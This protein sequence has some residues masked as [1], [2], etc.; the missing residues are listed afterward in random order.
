MGLLCP[1]WIHLLN[2]LPP[3]PQNLFVYGVFTETFYLK[4]DHLG[5]VLIQYG[6]CPK[7]R[8]N[9]DI[10]MY[11]QEESCVNMKVDIYKP[12]RE[13]QNRY[14]P[15]NPQK[16]PRTW[17]WTANPLNQC[18]PLIIINLCCLGSLFVILCYGIPSKLIQRA[19]S[20]CDNKL[21]LLLEFNFKF[22][23]DYSLVQT[24]DQPD[25]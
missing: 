8:G 10:E 17:T 4:W 24:C 21:S 22:C 14:F 9:L 13:A 12:K 23:I 16:E 20:N 11:I 5:W 3:V 25:Y 18:E 7:N 1:L 2:S 15:Q 19:W 6:W